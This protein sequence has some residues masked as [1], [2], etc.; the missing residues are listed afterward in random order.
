[1]NNK[2]N[3]IHHR[4]RLFPNF[5]LLIITGFF[6]ITGCGGEKEILAPQVLGIRTSIKRILINP[7]AF[8]GAIVALE[9]IARDMEEESS[10]ND[11]PKTRFKLADLSGNYISV[12]M[13]TSWVVEENDFVVVGGIYRR[14]KDEI[15]AKQLEVIVL[16]D[17]EEEEAK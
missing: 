3:C 6:I 12:S 7:L 16:E 11:V 5:V 10:V 17:E 13:P 15:E 1:M 9:G 2:I 8:D 4:N 14:A